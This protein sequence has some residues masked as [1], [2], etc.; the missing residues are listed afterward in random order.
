MAVTRIAPAGYARSFDERVRLVLPEAARRCPGFARRLAAAGMAADELVSV[1]DLDRLPVMT[2]DALIDLQKADPPFAGLVAADARIRRV[3]QSPG[4]LYEPELDRPDPWRWA[5][6]LR[7]AGF[8]GQD[9]VLNAFG[10]HLS[11]AGAMFEEAV[12]AVG[13]RVLPGGVGNLELQAQACADLGVTAYIGLPSYLKALL[14]RAEAAGHD[15]S[16]WP[17]TR[18]FVAAEPL[19]PSLRAWLAERIP[20][21]L[22]GYGTAETGNLGYETDALD[23]LHVPADALVQICDLSTGEAIH[24]GREG[25]VVVTIFE[26]DAPVV[27]FGTG[28]LSAWATDETTSAE[29]TPRI[30]GWLGRVGD[31]VKVRGMFLHPR[32]VNAV[33]TSVEGVEA[34]RLIIDRINHRDVLRCE[35]VTEAGADPEVVARNVRSSVRSG[36]RFDLDVVPVAEPTAADGPIVDSRSWD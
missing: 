35:L 26:P 1:G 21:V 10:Y 4:P 24:D 13:G 30:R 18:A 11:P 33:M 15:V 14:E 28:D 31:A 17:L 8:T 34:Y 20:V 23:G 29:P 3:F 7:A 22:Q 9:V 2:K 19:P 32:Q 36:L 12:R 6:A 16:A 5:P 27:R 25:E